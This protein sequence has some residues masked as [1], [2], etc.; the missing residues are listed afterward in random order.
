LSR[1]AETIGGGILI[2][3]GLNILHEHGALSFFLN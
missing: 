1:Y 2:A 3:I